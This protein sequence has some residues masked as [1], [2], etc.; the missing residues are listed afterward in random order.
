MKF[1]RMDL[2]RLGRPLRSGMAE[3]ERVLWQELRHGRLH[4]LQFYRQKPLLDFIVDFYCPRATLVVELDGS[5]HSD[6]VHSERDR[7]R[8]SRLS[9][10]GLTVLRFDN[11]QV[12]LEREAV[13][14]AIEKEMMA[15]L[16]K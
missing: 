11:R 7:Q 3:A 9:V 2:K 15:R 12:L 8:D 1:Y 5:Q 14:T 13:V 4:G 10:L 6:S 16:A